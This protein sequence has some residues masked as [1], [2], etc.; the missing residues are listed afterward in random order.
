MV[1]ALTSQQ[2]RIVASKNLDAP[3]RMDPQHAELRSNKLQIVPKSFIQD[4]VPEELSKPY[5]EFLQEHHVSLSS[6]HKDSVDI[7]SKVTRS[8]F[9]S[10]KGVVV[11]QF[12]HDG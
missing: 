7:K 8:T 9:L 3:K 11:S 5:R 6:F 10:E 4:Y 2:G 1:H 12:R